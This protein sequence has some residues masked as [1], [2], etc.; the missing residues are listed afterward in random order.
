MS[1]TPSHATYTEKC[2]TKEEES[3]WMEMEEDVC[4]LRDLHDQKK[5]RIDAAENAAEL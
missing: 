5:T 2:D 3:S 1:A 4:P